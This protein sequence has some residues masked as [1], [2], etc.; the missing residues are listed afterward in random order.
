MGGWGEGAQLLPFS[1][2]KVSLPCQCSLLWSVQN[3]TN[4]TEI[5]GSAHLLLITLTEKKSPPPPVLLRT[6]ICVLSL[7]SVQKFNKSYLSLIIPA[8][9]W[10][11]VHNYGMLLKEH[12]T[13][14]LLIQLWF[15]GKI[16]S[17]LELDDS[18]HEQIIK[19]RLTH[20][21][22]LSR[23]IKESNPA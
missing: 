9:T 1:S 6:L 18:D 15:L 14:S 10:T 23:K 22:T 4:Q 11:M 16:M 19:P 2:V 8:D 3:K 17:F 21:A 12:S 7:K 13:I 20:A 5:N